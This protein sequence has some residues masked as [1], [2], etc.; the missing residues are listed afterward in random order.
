MLVLISVVT[1][2]TLNG[3]PTARLC[4]FST[5]KTVPNILDDNG[6]TVSAIG[7]INDIYNGFALHN[8]KD[9]STKTEWIKRLPA[10]YEFNGLIFTN[11]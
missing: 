1:Q 10:R 9:I 11:R 8:T 3:P 5:G 2:A 7:K 4:T 6:I